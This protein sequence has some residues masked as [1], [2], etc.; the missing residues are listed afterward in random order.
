M[1]NIYK[2]THGPEDWKE[3]LGQPDLHWKPGY[4]AKAIAHCWEASAGLPPEIA[5]A[6]TNHFGEPPEPLFIVPE[7]KVPMPASSAGPSQNDV[8]LFCRIAQETAVVMVEG[9]VNETFGP[10]INEWLCQSPSAKRPIRIQSLCDMLGVN[11]DNVRHLRYQLFHR[12]ASA[13]IEADRFC[14]THAV[15]LVHSFSDR[16][17]WFDDFSAFASELGCKPEVGTLTASHRG[18]R[19]LNL[20]WVNGDPSY[21]KA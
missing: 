8:F 2:P 18:R 19:T 9:K 17:Q 10:T 20:G 12:A 21:L 6:L 7:Y 11:F 3:F 15:M 13:I 5:F 16:H 4:S 14:A 1:P